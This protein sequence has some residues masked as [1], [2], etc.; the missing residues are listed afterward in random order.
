MA[1]KLPRSTNRT[2]PAPNAPKANPERMKEILDALRR[3]QKRQT[4]KQAQTYMA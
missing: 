3:N 2:A 4:E 1:A